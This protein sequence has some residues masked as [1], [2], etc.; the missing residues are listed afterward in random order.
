MRVKAICKSV[1]AD[2]AHPLYD[3]LLELDVLM[4][5]LASLWSVGRFLLR[6]RIG[7]TTRPSRLEKSVERRYARREATPSKCCCCGLM[8]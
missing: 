7:R 6:T 5:L 3:P 8:S 2:E 4:V 1:D